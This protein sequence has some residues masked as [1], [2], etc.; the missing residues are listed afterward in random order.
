[1][2]AVQLIAALCAGAGV[3]AITGAMVR[4]GVKALGTPVDRAAAR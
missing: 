2:P 4:L 3:L 1:V